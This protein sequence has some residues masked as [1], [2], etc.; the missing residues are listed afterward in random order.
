MRYQERGKF[1]IAQPT[2][3]NGDAKRFKPS[4]LPFQIAFAGNGHVDGQALRMQ[5]IECRNKERQ[6]FVVHHPTE[7]QKTQWPLS[8]PHRVLNLLGVS[9]EGVKERDDFFAWNEPL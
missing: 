7:E 9:H 4:L 2:I 8:V 6:T 5:L 1:V 3:D